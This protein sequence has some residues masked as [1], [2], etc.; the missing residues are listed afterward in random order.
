MSSSTGGGLGLHQ[1]RGALS[2]VEGV[3]R[4]AAMEAASPDSGVLCT[5]ACLSSLH[6]PSCT[7]L[8]GGPGLLAAHSEYRSQAMSCLQW[9]TLAVKA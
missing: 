9:R 1:L 5:H 4:V 6:L 2:A 8:I 3:G 7:G